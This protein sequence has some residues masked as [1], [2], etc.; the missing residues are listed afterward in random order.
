MALFLVQ[1]PL[2]MHFGTVKLF[3]PPCTSLQVSEVFNEV[4]KIISQ[5]PVKDYVPYSWG[6]LVHV[7]KEHYKA[8]SHYFVAQ[9]I[10]EHKGGE[11]SNKTLETLTFLHEEDED[12]AATMS[13]I[14]IR[15]PKNQN[16]RRYLGKN[17]FGLYHTSK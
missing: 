7:K 12:K 5:P 14:E 15:V 1:I 11:F 16:E 6:S 8:L 3:F 17:F 9:G 10:L 13:L 4:L 2:R